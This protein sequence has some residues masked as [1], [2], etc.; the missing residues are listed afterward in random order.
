M[1]CVTSNLANRKLLTDNVVDVMKSSSSI[2]KQYF[3]IKVGLNSNL[4]CHC[5]LI[6]IIF[7]Q[8]NHRWCGIRLFYAT[9]MFSTKLLNIS[10]PKI[11]IKRLLNLQK[12]YDVIVVGG[13][14][15][16][17]EACAASVRM[18]AN[19]LLVTHKKETIGT[20]LYI[21]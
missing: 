19:T 13:G 1:I 3:N 9:K 5:K 20:V 4:N 17:T 15:A 11:T 6:K 10:S 7:V 18:G 16:G 14:H 8:Y 12:S 2:S 21:V